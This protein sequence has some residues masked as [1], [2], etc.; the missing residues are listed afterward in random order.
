M[1]TDLTYPWYQ[2]ALQTEYFVTIVNV[3][4]GSEQP[5]VIGMAHFSAIQ[6]GLH[7]KYVICRYSNL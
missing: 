7:T 1:L 6:Q 4:V 2:K 3:H 5:Y